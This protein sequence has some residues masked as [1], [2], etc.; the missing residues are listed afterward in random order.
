MV[1]MKFYVAARFEDKDLI[2]K[3]HKK[4]LLKGHEIVG[5]WLEHKF[6]KPYEKNQKLSAEYS[7][8]D[9]SAVLDCDI[10]VVLADSEGRGKIAEFGAALAANK[11]LG[12]P[13]IFVIGKTNTDF[14]FYFHPAV[15]RRQN[16]D[17]ILK[18]V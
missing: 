17:D 8:A 2:K 14:M 3:I 15:N 4:I 13:K 9:I 16:I 10:F 5:N 6:V 12:K 18:E 11:T 1:V 7:L